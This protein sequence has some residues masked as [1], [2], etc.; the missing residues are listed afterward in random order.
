M[1]SQRHT[2][3][4]VSQ[5]KANSNIQQTINFIPLLAV[6]ILMIIMY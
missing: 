2:N 6:M 1:K 4:E 3:K 5:G